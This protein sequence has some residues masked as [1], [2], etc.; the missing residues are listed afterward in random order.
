MAEGTISSRLVNTEYD[1]LEGITVVP[2][3]N[4][5]DWE[6]SHLTRIK[7]YATHPM[8]NADAAKYGKYMMEC[9]ANGTSVNSD[10][11]TIMLNLAISLRNPTNIDSRLL[12]G[13]PHQPAN[14]NILPLPLPELIEDDPDN[15]NNDLLDRIRATAGNMVQVEARDGEGPSEEDLRR[16]RGNDLRIDEE[17]L[18]KQAAFYCYLSA[19]LMRIQSR[20]PQN[21]AGTIQ[22]AVERFKG[23]YEMDPVEAETIN[24]S[25]DSLVKLKEVNARRPEITG[26]WVMWIAH[27]ENVSTNLLTQSRGMLEYLGLQVFAYQG[28][29][30]LPQVL[31]IHQIS[32]V[33]LKELLRELDSPMTRDGLRQ[34]VKILRFHE[35]TTTSTGRKTYFRYA[36]VW[37]KK[38]F[39]ALQSKSC[40]PLFYVAAQVV[41]NL[42]PN[43]SSDPTQAYAL[44]NIGEQLKIGLTKVATKLTASLLQNTAIDAKSGEIWDAFTE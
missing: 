33:P 15:E 20:S 38:Y 9:L 29:H 24:I 30:T 12:V 10:L 7:V 41:K 40:V 5:E 31:A 23:W 4:A 37:D 3:V 19:F 27:T 1:E 8:D 6:D 18:D 26:T 42:S 34:I 22:R 43:S 32:K 16:E 28:M 36:R 13:I 11:V 21:V 44:K 17:P 35:I 14:V 25:M 39:A 2:G